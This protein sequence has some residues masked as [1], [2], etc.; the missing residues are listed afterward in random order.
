MKR[1]TKRYLKVKSNLSRNNDR[2]IT[3]LA[4]AVNH[5]IAFN[6]KRMIYRTALNPEGEILV[7]WIVNKFTWLV[8]VGPAFN[9]PAV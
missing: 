8:P 9:F 1:C 3:I 4:V 7:S 6:I 5:L 2:E